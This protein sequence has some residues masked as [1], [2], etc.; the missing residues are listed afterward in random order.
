M[1]ADA[2]NNVKVV[3][4]G[5]ILNNVYG[6]VAVYTV[7]GAKVASLRMQGGSK[8]IALAAGNYVV[9]ASGMSMSIVVK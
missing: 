2:E 1:E 9:K 5:I 6:D 7:G 3:A 4:D 8:H